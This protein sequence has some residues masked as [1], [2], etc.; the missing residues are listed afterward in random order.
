MAFLY[1]VVPIIF[2]LKQIYLNDFLVSQKGMAL[3]YTYRAKITPICNAMETIF[4]SKFPT[5]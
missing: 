5:S 4:N 2:H 1:M 3:T